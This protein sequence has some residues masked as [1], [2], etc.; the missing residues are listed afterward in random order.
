[1][2]IVRPVR[3]GLW[4]P[5]H[6]AF[7]WLVNGGYQLF[8]EKGKFRLQLWLYIW[9]IYWVVPP[10]SNCGKWRFIGIPDPKNV[11]I[12]VVT[13]ILGGGSTQSIYAKFLGVCLNNNFGMRTVSTKNS[14]SKS[15]QL[16]RYGCDP[17]I[18]MVTV[19]SSNRV[20]SQDESI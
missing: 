13:G 17:K 6:M 3:I 14:L 4:E 9:G 19:T 2:V 5:F 8:L 15:G 10:P 18:L 7:S 20:A 16:G 11:I 1:M 12:L